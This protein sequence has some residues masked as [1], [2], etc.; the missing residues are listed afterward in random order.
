[1]GF[2]CPTSPDPSLDEVALAAVSNDGFLL[3]LITPQLQ[4]DRLGAPEV[5]GLD[6]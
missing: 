2:G 1:M 5:G 6:H 3:T 4:R